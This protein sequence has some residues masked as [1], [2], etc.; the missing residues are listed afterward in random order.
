M[1]DKDDILLNVNINYNNNQIKIGK[2]KDLPSIDVIKNKIMRYLEIPNTKDYLYLSYK[3]D[4]GSGQKIGDDENIFKYAK[5][6][7]KSHQTEY[8]LELDLSIS[9]E[10]DKFKKFF[11]ANFDEN[12]YNENKKEL[13]RIIKENEIV[14]N[15]LKEMEKSKIEELENL[16]KKIKEMKE[17]I[18]IKERIKNNKL[19]IELLKKELEDK[20]LKYY[21]NEFSKRFKEQINKFFEDKIQTFEIEAKKLNDQ[22]I[23]NKDNAIITFKEQILKSI[24]DLKKEKKEL[25][26]KNIN[27]KNIIQKIKKDS[28][29]DKSL[30]NS[31]QKDSEL[32]NS[33]LKGKDS[34]NLKVANNNE[35]SFERKPQDSLKTKNKSNFIYKDFDIIYNESLPKDEFFN[36]LNEIFFKSQN[37]NLTED[38]QNTLKNYHYELKN[39]KENALTKLKIFYEKKMLFILGNNQINMQYKTF[40]ENKIKELE[41]Y[42]KR[43]SL[44]KKD[45]LEQNNTIKQNNNIS[46]K[47]KNYTQSKYN[48]NFNPNNQK[49]VAYNSFLNNSNKNNYQNNN[50]QKLK[51]QNSLSNNHIT[52][53]YSSIENN[54]YN[55]N[56]LASNI[57]FMNCNF[58]QNNYGY[59]T[60][61][62]NKKYYNQ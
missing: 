15:K 7:P 59:K 20:N 8:I 2:V 39:S 34:K 46:A 10:V 23:R 29:K 4:K 60:Q 32:D 13:D 56:R 61:Y 19:L 24:N 26:E 50:N 37:Q 35:Q 62:Y 41:N 3:D 58:N 55:Q 38:E 33:I 30:N 57:E 17:K 6:K 40:L 48:N 21:I 18:I 42:L 28:E 11:N 54:I 45:I 49:N 25:E 44:D 5:E 27:Y 16:I 47:E 9:D 12:K 51:K 14:K 53:R 52:P 31:S 43:K 36:F 22:I 1:V